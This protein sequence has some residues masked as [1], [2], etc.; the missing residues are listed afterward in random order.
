MKKCNQCGIF[1]KNDRMVCPL[2]QHGLETI[3]KEEYVPAYPSVSFDVHKYHIIIRIFLFISIVLEAALLIINYLTFTGIWWALIC[4]GAIAYFWLTMKFSIQ[5]NT[6]HATKILV[7]TIAAMGLTVF[8]DWTVGYQGWSVNY[9][10]P[11]IVMIAYVAILILMAVNFMNWPSYLLFQIELV[12]LSLLLFV[13]N[14]LG[15]V[16]NPVLTYIAA[17]ST[18]I[19][20]I[21]T[22]IFGDKKAKNEFKRR[23]H[24]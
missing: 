16:T 19:I 2:C 13:F 5:N 4:G 6:N 20:L 14:L 8:I 7:Q 21:G 10:L 12:I 15:F 3:E 18:S 1:I 22:I 23:F 17:A 24:I 11:A 9:A